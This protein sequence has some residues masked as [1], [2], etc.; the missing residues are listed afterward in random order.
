MAAKGRNAVFVVFSIFLYAPFLA[1]FILAFQGPQGGLNFPLRDP[2]LHWFHDLIDPRSLSDFRPA[3]GRS[4]ILALVASAITT[5]VSLAAGLA[6]RRRFTG[7]ATLF[8]LTIGSLV[9]PSSLVSIGIGIICSMLGIQMTWWGSALGAQLTW[10]LPFGVLIMLAVFSHFDR[11]LEEAA[12]DLGANRWQVLRHVTI[13]VVAPGL[14]AVALLSFMLSYDE[15]A[16]TAVVA[17]SEN[18]L[19]LELFAFMSLSVSP[20]IYALGTVTTLLSIGALV[21][22]T[23]VLI[24][25]A[26]RRRAP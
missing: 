14:F 18:T 20:T 10:T 17:G 7:S 9:V 24:R 22:A 3:I 4:V 6:F 2:S 26:N 8:Y 13:P 5:I 12:R 11:S 15:F 16:R 25:S 19:P 21:I 1:I 23:A